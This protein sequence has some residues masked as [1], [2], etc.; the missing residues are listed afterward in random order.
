MINWSEI[1]PSYFE[2]FIHYI[3]GKEGFFNRQWFGRGGG[4]SGRD[5]VAYTSENLP[6]H[7]GYQ[8]KWIF[9]CKRWRKHPTPTQL[10][11]EILTAQQHKPDFWVM[12]IPLN[13]TASQMDY[14]D[15]LNKN[16]NFVYGK[17]LM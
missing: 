10:M 7:L 8:R 16:G 5:V 12:V 1:N 14:I 2:K 11:N 15:N 3:L 9:Q 6:F 4:D 17:L 13:L